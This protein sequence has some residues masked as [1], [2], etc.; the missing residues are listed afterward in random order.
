MN[1]NQNNY[2][3]MNNVSPQRPLPPQPPQKG[4]GFLLG[5]MLGIAAPLLVGAFVFVGVK[6]Y[7]AVESRK[8][9]EKRRSSAE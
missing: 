4:G 8:V 7:E 2:Y 5:M 1:Q 9:R 6:F 3:Y